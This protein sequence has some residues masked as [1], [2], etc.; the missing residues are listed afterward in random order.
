MLSLIFPA[1][2]SDDLTTLGIEHL[3]FPNRSDIVECIE[4][5]DHPLIDFLLDHANYAFR[6][7]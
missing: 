3:T 6:I 2:F 1:S 4:S 7:N 5:V